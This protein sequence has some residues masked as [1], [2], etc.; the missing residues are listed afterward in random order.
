VAKKFSGLR[1]QMSPE[2]LLRVYA[3]VRAELIEI[4]RNA[5]EAGLVVLTRRERELI[6]E[7]IAGRVRELRDVT[8]R[9]NTTDLQFLENALRK[10]RHTL[11]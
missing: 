5:E 1:E 4:T 2:A 9:D 8:R 10:I 3:R 11:E 7:V 6:E